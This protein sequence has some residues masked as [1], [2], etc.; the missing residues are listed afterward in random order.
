MVE[1]NRA[2][3]GRRPRGFTLIELL[4]AM[5]VAAILASIAL[6]SFADALRRAR[7]VEA[8]GALLQ[9]QLAQERWRADHTRYSGQLTDLGIPANTPAGT[10]VVAVQ[11]ADDTGFV[12]TATAATLQAGD[13]P[14]RVLKL[15]ARG[16]S[17]VRASLD[18]AGVETTDP[19]NRCWR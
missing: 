11:E 17:F 3:P 13:T 14:C 19:A 8:M 18:G 2:R 16:G 10:Y 15:V 5:V 6:P 1:Y 7:R 12:A 9:L 4:I